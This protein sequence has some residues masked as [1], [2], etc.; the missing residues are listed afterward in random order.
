MGGRYRFA[1]TD[2]GPL[3]FVLTFKKSVQLAD[4]LTTP[5]RTAADSV[6]MVRIPS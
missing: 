5:T 3:G 4:T 1:E 2:C 6:F